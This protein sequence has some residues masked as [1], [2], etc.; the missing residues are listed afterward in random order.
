MHKLLQVIMHLK[1]VIE[2]QSRGLNSWLRRM[3]DLM[4]PCKVWPNNWAKLN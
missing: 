3:L 1:L 4:K 2:L